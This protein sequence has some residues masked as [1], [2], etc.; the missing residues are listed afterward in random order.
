MEI[1]IHSDTKFLS[2]V[3]AFISFCLSEEDMNDEFKNNIIVSIIEAVTNAIIHGNKLIYS[4]K[5]KVKV[6]F[7]AHKFVVEV[8]DEGNGFNYK[9]VPN[10]L[11]DERLLEPNGRGLFI[12]NK[13]AESVVHTGNG[14]TVKLTFNLKK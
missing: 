2:E 3:E 1:V 12:M 13:L 14:N 7:I 10:P 6:K 11:C 8:Q 4:R 5:V 9:N